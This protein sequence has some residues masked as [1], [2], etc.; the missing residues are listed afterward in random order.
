MFNRKLIDRGTT[1]V[2]KM[3]ELPINP[4][5]I[6]RYNS[7]KK[8]GYTTASSLSKQRMSSKHII[9]QPESLAAKKPPCRPISGAPRRKTGGSSLATIGV[10][11]HSGLRTDS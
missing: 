6:A 8:G 1:A 4:S 10:T 2:I 11:S 7:V 9:T 3:E 5:D